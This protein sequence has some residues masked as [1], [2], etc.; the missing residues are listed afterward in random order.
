VGARV[1][2]DHGGK[3]RQQRGY[4][5]AWV[6]VRA[7]VLKRDGCRCQC[8]ECRTSG[9]L[10]AATEVDHIESKA[11]WLR[12][13]GSLEGVDDPSNLQAI[14]RECHARKTLV[15]RGGTHRPPR[16]RIGTDGYPF[17]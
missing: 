17:T 13:T 12:R 4:G 8:A 5:A 9:R 2:W 7:H 3:T 11:N 6:R 1:S 14:N 15:E 16:L 10:L